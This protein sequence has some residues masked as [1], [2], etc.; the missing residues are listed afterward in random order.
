MNAVFDAIAGRRSIRS[1]RP[2]PL[3]REDVERIV[4]AGLYAPSARNRQPWHVTALLGQSR[5]DRVTAELK[6]AVVRMPDNPYK[7]FVGKA[8]Y[9]VN[10]RAP[11]FIMVSADPQASV[12]A[13]ADCALVL[14][15]MF[16]AA[17]ALGIGSCW[18]NQL[19]S[20]CADAGFRAFLTELGLPPGHYIYGSACFG[21][22]QGPAPTAPP[23]R[24]GTVTYLE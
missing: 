4:T 16:L 2:A 14:Q 21:Y 24:E 7:A 20:A 3:A 9:T 15:N 12:M 1:Y 8:D 19:G 22:A 11:V 18:I 10:Y 5:I 6:A 13:M 23:R 17:Q